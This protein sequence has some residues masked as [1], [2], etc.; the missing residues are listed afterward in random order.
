MRWS[1][2]LCFWVSQDAIL[3]IFSSITSSAIR[4]WWEEMKGKVFE[5]HKTCIEFIQT[6]F[7]HKKMGS[8]KRYSMESRKANLRSS[9]RRRWSGWCSFHW[10]R[11]PWGK[12]A[13]VRPAR[14]SHRPPRI[15]RLPVEWRWRKPVKE[16]I[17]SAMDRIALVL[18]ILCFVH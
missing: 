18:L 16:E 1:I 10:D 17:S 7:E 2:K 4:S 13:C 8:F 12:A 9:K 11:R 15:S 6:E 3:T 5:I 14:T